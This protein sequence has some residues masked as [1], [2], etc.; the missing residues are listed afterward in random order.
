MN[1]KRL[2]GLRAGAVII[3][4]GLIVGGCASEPPTID[5]GPGAEVTYDGLHRVLN[6]Q[7]DEAWARPDIDLSVYT[8]VR[9]VGAGIQFRPGGEARRTA[10]AR[11]TGGPFVVTEQQ[12]EALGQIVA[13]AFLEE[14]TSSDRFT[15]V[16]E[17]DLDVLLIRGALLDVVSF[18]PPESVGRTE[19]FLRSVGEATLVLELRD[20][21]TNTVL[22]RSIDRRAA[23][24]PG[25]DIRWSTNVSNA[26]EVRRLARRWA[27]RLREALDEFM[28]PA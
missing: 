8:K 28:G 19:V 5:T 13:A 26:A 22:A 11:Q 27:T 9:F 7:A 25:G 21:V 10:V 4:L 1:V 16:E 15:L 3:A 24:N 17:D 14:L 2:P 23:E 6:A 18:V 20:S 12:K